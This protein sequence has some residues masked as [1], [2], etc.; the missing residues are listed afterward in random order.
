ME[1][2][3]LDSRS[4]CL[5][6]AHPRLLQ[7]AMTHIDNQK[8]KIVETLTATL[9]IARW[10]G[11]LRGGVVRKFF[12]QGLLESKKTSYMIIW[13]IYKKKPQGVQTCTSLKESGTSYWLLLYMLDSL[14]REKYRFN[15]FLCFKWV[16]IH[17]CTWLFIAV[18]GCYKVL[19]DCD[20]LYM[21]AHGCTRLYMDVHSCTWL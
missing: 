6:V 16:T 21:V 2:G 19:Q 7:N 15:E 13:V 5:A 18:H 1:S 12:K 17:G 10:T 8:P 9:P 14:L 4:L 20:R 3:C 11:I